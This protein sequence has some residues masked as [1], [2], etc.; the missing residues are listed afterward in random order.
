MTAQDHPRSLS[1]PHPGQL[2]KTQPL[3]V[4]R[5]P[6]ARLSFASFHP[7]TASNV[8]P[9]N[10]LEGTSHTKRIVI[11]THPSRFSHWRF[12]PRA[13]LGEGVS[14]EGS[15]PRLVDV[16]GYVGFG[17]PAK[18]YFSD[19]CF[20]VSSLY[21]T[22]TNGI[23]INLIHST[24]VSSQLRRRL[25]RFAPKLLRR[26]HFPPHLHLRDH[27]FLQRAL[28][29]EGG[30]RALPQV[31]RRKPDT[32]PKNGGMKFMSS[33]RVVTNRRRRRLQIPTRLAQLH[34]RMYLAGAFVGEEGV[35]TAHPYLEL[36]GPTLRMLHRM[37]FTTKRCEVL[38]HQ[39]DLHKLLPT[40]HFPSGG[41]VHFFLLICL[42]ANPDSARVDEEGSSPVTLEDNKPAKRARTL[43]PDSIRR[44][45]TA[46]LKERVR[47]RIRTDEFMRRMNAERDAR[48]DAR[49]QALM[50]DIIA[51][52]PEEYT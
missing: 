20:S 47:V 46:R 12:V 11:E 8:P 45:A 36:H 9:Y 33:T 44:K 52:M 17:Q 27:P 37:C 43:S 6:D 23:Y 34:G 42:T 10:P 51:E 32:R 26:R 49:D 39:R 7:Q 15:W 25:L 30:R 1:G 29:R 5:H 41:K 21:A 19:K 28:K 14:D 38:R 22:K 2:D 3:R 40:R 24:I 16:L 50:E 18:A 31:S 48:R 4:L 35:Y 13:Q